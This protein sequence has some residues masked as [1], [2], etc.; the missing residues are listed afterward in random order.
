MEEAYSEGWVKRF[1]LLLSVERCCMGICIRRPPGNMPACFR[2]RFGN[3]LTD[4]LPALGGC[5][6]G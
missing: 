3:K 5:E 6:C 4:E 2:A 1:D